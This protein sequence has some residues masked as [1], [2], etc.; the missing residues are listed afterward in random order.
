MLDNGG[1]LHKNR[2]L[3]NSADYSL[4]SGTFDPACNRPYQIG[5][6]LSD[7]QRQKI[8]AKP[9]RRVEIGTG[10]ITNEDCQCPL[11]ALGIAKAHSDA[12][13]AEDV[14]LGLYHGWME[15]RGEEPLAY[16]DVD[17]FINTIA[18]AA[19]EFIY[20]WDN[21]RIDPDWLANVLGA[22]E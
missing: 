8:L 21:G 15:A 22:T 18:S 3:S 10:V 4:I 19:E 11:G 2:V 14:A 7:D 9:Y 1:V 13:C 16:H 12:P 20:D 5:R 17:E 6:Y